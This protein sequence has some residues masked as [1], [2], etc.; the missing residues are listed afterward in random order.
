MDNGSTAAP[1]PATT[2][3][4]TISQRGQSEPPPRSSISRGAPSISRRQ[5]LRAPAPA[6]GRPRRPGCVSSRP[7][8]GGSPRRQRPPPELVAEE[9]AADERAPGRGI[10]PARRRRSLPPPDRRRRSSTV[11]LELHEGIFR[12]CSRRRACRG[13]A[14]EKTSG[15]RDPQPPARLGPAAGDLQADLLHLGQTALRSGRTTCGRRRSAGT[16]ARCAQSAACR[17]RPP[18]A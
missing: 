9:A 15:A 11:R 4:R 6:R 16:H 8:A 18:A 7:P 2:A 10:D 5:L 13:N 17:A 3:S 12:P 14:W 1:A